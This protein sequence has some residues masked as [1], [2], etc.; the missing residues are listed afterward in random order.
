MSTC[1]SRKGEKGMNHKRICDLCGTKETE[2]TV[3]SKHL[4]YI[5]EDLK[6]YNEFGTNH[7]VKHICKDCFM[8]LFTKKMSHEDNWEEVKESCK[9]L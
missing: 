7:I 4:S 8:K 5:D 9:E 2:F 3:T 6:K 1:G